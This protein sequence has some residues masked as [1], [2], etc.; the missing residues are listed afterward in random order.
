LVRKLRHNGFVVTQFRK[1]WDEFKA[2]PSG[3][4]FQQLHRR[5]EARRS[6]LLRSTFL[7]L[8]LVVMAA[9]L[10][11]MPAPGPGTVIFILGAAIAAQESERVARAMDW[12]ELRLRQAARRARSWWRRRPMPAKVLLLLAV[13]AIAASAGV[14]GYKLLAA[15]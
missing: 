11:L 6:A 10:F 2:A 12:G 5:R 1:L 13:L 9:G 8:G 15:R 4:R 3:E 14:A 7:I